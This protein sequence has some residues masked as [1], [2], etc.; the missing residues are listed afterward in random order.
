MELSRL[1]LLFATV[2]VAVVGVAPVPAQASFSSASAPP[3]PPPPAPGSSQANPIYPGFT[4]W[5]T[6][7]GVPYYNAQF[8]APSSNQWYSTSVEPGG[9]WLYGI[10]SADLSLS[11][12]ASFTSITAP[13]GFGAMTLSAGNIVLDADFT[14][15]EVLTFASGVTQV[16]LTLNSPPVFAPG[17]SAANSFQV[18]VGVTG[19]AQTMYLS[20]FGVAPVPETSTFALTLLGLLGLGLLT[21]GVKRKSS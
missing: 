17:S 6:A 8:S 21:T 13:E 2:A 10:R 9:L 3:P 20:M 18:K 4:F 7:S 11:G 5:G 1:C 19:S 16:K 12:N 14:S 15:G